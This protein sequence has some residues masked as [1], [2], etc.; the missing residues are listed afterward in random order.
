MEST[1]E[2]VTLNEGGSMGEAV[3]TAHRRLPYQN[4]AWIT[5]QMPETHLLNEYRN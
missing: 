2:E 5:G 3:G 4:G 1:L